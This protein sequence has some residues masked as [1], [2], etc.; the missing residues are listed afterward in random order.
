M[1]Y[2]TRM[3][4]KTNEQ[5]F[6]ILNNAGEYHPDAIEAVN[7]EIANRNLDSNTKITLEENAYRKEALKIEKANEPLNLISKILALIIPFYGT[8]LLYL[9][10]G[11]T[12]KHNELSRWRMYGLICYSI[13]FILIWL[14]II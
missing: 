12:R 9:A 8:G 5:L 10:D 3:Q 7:I 11:Y 14:G 6:D 4:S 2:K 13:F 1:N